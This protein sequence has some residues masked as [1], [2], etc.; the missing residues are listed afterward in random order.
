MRVARVN[1]DREI[2]KNYHF[3]LTKFFKKNFQNEV[4]ST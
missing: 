3:Q 1:G 2:A 4:L